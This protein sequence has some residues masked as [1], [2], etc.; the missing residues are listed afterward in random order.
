MA[1][2]LS[3]KE[4]NKLIDND[5]IIDGDKNQVRSNSY[6][7]RLGEEV[8]FLSTNE[9][10]EGDIGNILVVGP[11]D[12]AMVISL[13]DLNLKNIDKLFKS[14]QI[15]GFLTPPTTLIREGINLPSTKIDPGFKGTL[16]WTIKN[17]SLQPLEL[18]IGEPIYKCTF[19]LLTEEEEIPEFLYGERDDVDFYQGRT[20][21]VESKRRLPVDK[22]KRKKICVSS[23][24]TEF[25]RLKQAGF[26]YDFIGTQLQQ[27]GGKLE[28]VSKD[29]VRIKEQ[30]GR[31]EEKIIKDI[32][33]NVNDIV[34]SKLIYGAGT[35]FTIIFALGA[36]GK[37][38]I[39]EGKTIYIAPA[40]SGLSI[41]SILL[42]IL[43]FIVKRR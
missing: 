3:D 10:I 16:N 34:V 7:F 26:P 18:E 40:L 43:Y 25:Q 28:L 14:N 42:M 41:L 39:D 20:G 12:S 11:S 17:N 27:L 4:I 35:F 2:I 6:L 19:M 1:R 30:I 31:V 5:I 22:D 36:L 15:C 8:R 29:F 33:K 24:G 9:R 21:L 38:L 32:N 13:E 37:F 23:V